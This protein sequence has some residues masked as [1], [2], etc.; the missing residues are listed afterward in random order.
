MGCGRATHEDS[1][2]ADNPKF[3]ELP[4]NARCDANAIGTPMCALDQGR[5]IGI[6][7]DIELG[8]SLALNR[9]RP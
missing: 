3:Q 5:T 2:N 7:P 1:C 6:I 4:Q 8:N 9:R